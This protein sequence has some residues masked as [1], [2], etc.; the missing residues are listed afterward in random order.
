LISGY[1][2]GTVLHM[3]NEK[4][5]PHYGLNFNSTPPGTGTGICTR[6]TAGR[7]KD[8]LPTGTRPTNKSNSHT[9]T[10]TLTH[11]HKQL[12][13]NNSSRTGTIPI[14]ALASFPF[15]RP[16]LQHPGPLLLG[17]S[18]SSSSLQVAHH[19][20]GVG[21]SEGVGTGVLHHITALFV[22]SCVRVFALHKQKYKH[23]Y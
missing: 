21:N 11:K 2:T 18:S 12:H 23:K 16:G 5:S 17:C 22:Y 6:K 14:Q 10:H 8:L 15:H 13:W 7:E 19:G 1:V 20:V 4:P 9:S 3:K